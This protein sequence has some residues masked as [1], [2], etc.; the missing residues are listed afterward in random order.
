[1]KTVCYFLTT[2]EISGG[3]K[4]L[5]RLMNGIRSYAISPIAVIPTRGP[6]EDE[7]KTAKIPYFVV[8]TL[9]FKMSS[10]RRLRQV[11]KI[12]KLLRQHRV[13]IIH[14]NELPYRLSSLA[15]GSKTAKVL[16]VHHPGF[17][18]KSLMWITKCTPDAII[19]PSR[20]I[21]GMVSEYT[22][23]KSLSDRTVSIYN[24]IDTEWFAPQDVA[25]LRCK[26]AFSQDKFHIAMLG[27]ITPHKGQDIA[28]RAMAKVCERT[29]QTQLHIIGSAKPND[30]LYL[31][32][33]HALVEEL[34][35]QSNVRFWGG[36]SDEVARDTLA[37][38]DLFVLP[39]R[40]EGFGLVLAEAQAC[41]VPVVS[42]NIKPIDE[43]VMH[44]K[45]GYLVDPDFP[46]DFATRIQELMDSSEIRH[47]F[48]KAG[49]QHVSE[50]FSEKRFVEETVNMYRSIS[51]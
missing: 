43:V 5:Q 12:R 48:G 18:R 40:E 41:E 27:T 1:M 9:G 17:S 32:S 6:V 13:D 24:P 16:H 33:L 49:R 35:L 39:T 42:T 7:L 45:T 21:H 26:L 51:K 34:G 29:P 4:V 30:R 15:V 47:R 31:P 2:S 28:I 38:S 46:G 20:F 19:T 3:N 8:D 11:L 44:G 10:I 14:A 25:S 50:N 36:V 37:A 23:C 22:N